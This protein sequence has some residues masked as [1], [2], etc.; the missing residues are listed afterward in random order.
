VVKIRQTTK[1]IVRS[2][3][4]DDV[5]IRRTLARKY[6]RRAGRRT[7]QILLAATNFILDSAAK[8][9]AALAIEDLTG[10]GKMYRKGNGQGKDYRFRLN[11]WPHWKGKR[12]LEYKA[13]WK[14]VTVIQLTK[15]ETTGP[16]R[17]ARRVEEALQP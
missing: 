16:R 2:F 11:S 14:G 8:N 12:V 9:G 10:I 17:Y 3:R 7:D 5:S 1:E 6:W 4:R 15:P 13:P